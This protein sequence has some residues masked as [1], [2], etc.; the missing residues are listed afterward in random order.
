MQHG[1]SPASHPRRAREREERERRREAAR[2]LRDENQRRRREV[3]EALD[4][5]LSER[6]QAVK[7]RCQLRVARVR[8]ETKGAR[9]R[10]RQELEER[11]R[12]ERD[13]ERA[14]RLHAKKRA[15]V[16]VVK[17][18]SDDEVRGN[19][20]EELVP[21]FNVVRARVRARPGMSR[22]EV[23][24]HW[25]E[26]NPHEVWALREELAEKRL[27]ALIREEQRARRE[28]QRAGGRSSA[29]ARRA[30]LPDAPF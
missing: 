26:E 29:K 15:R 4:R 24:L 18:E 23:F 20:D 2:R 7:N 11:R 10:A 19:L 16:H 27:R 3:L 25:L 21:I 17:A 22:T 13:V 8:E 30:A 12:A 14:E 1:H 5:E 6:R 9:A 28:L